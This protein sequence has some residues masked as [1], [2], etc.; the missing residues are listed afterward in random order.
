MTA[1]T[2]TQ[3][4]T[5]ATQLATV[6]GVANANAWTRVEG[7]ERVYVELKNKQSGQK[8]GGKLAVLADGTVEFDVR[9]GWSGAATRKFHEANN[10]VGL[11]RAAVEA[12]AAAQ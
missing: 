8:I 5:L 4:E 9:Q 10:T 2:A 12:F 6:E 3:I 7:R 11:I 1:L